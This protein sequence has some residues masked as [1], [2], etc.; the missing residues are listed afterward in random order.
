[1]ASAVDAR[2]AGPARAALDLPADLLVLVLLAVPA[3]L[4]DWQIASVWSWP[5]AWRLLWM[6]LSAGLVLAAVRLPAL[7]EAAMAGAVFSLYALPV[8]G[9]IVRWHLQTSGTAVIGD[10]ALQTQLAGSF[11]LRG[12]D[13]YGA[14]Y[15]AAG[16][17]RA[18]W[19]EPFASPALHHL[20]I[21]PGGFLL[22]L[23]LQALATAAL[24]W[25]DERWFLLLAAAAIWI[26][27]RR[28]LP[29]TPGRMAAIAVFLLPLHSLIAVLGD[30]DLPAVAL[31]L[32][33]LW[34]AERRRFLWM[35]A[36]L[37]LAIATKQHALLAVPIVLAWATV[38]EASRRALALAT[39]AGAAVC[40]AVVLPFLVWNPSAFVQDTVSFLVGGG[41]QAYPING[42]GLSAILLHAGVVHGPRDAFPFA[43]LEIAAGITVWIGAWRW[44]RRH[45]EPAD[46]LTWC[47][48]AFLL[49]LFVSRYFHD[50]HL[51][52][53]AELIAAG[54]LA[55]WAGW[56][57]R[58]RTVEAAPVRSA[59]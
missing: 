51:L 53:G 59:A 2:R 21:W 55:R 52:L 45:R 50:T 5:P 41:P 28:L 42:M 26:I 1:V 49:V 6:A 8:L 38:R 34:A 58:R 29:G 7:R 13:P 27:L 57:A 10:G 37:G 15:A 24:G 33:A 18:P 35:G 4:I 36:L 44:L 43:I 20:V 30:N 23:P 32:A 11:V 47:G 48:L 14:D 46:A 39:A 22:P 54:T 9:G 17:S 12:T 25:W 3:A 16:L 40:A 19:S 56:A 31:V